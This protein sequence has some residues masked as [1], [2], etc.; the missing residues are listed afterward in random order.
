MCPWSPRNPSSERDVQDLPKLIS[1]SDE[2]CSGGE[3]RTLNLARAVMTLT[4]PG[5]SFDIRLEQA[6]WAPCSP[7]R[8]SNCHLTRAQIAPK[9]NEVEP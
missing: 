9:V 5:L 4:R 1:Q 6:F 7:A 8:A 2:R 3:T